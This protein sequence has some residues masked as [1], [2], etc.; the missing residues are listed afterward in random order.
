MGLRLRIK[1]KTKI[2]ILEHLQRFLLR[3]SLC[4]MIMKLFMITLF[5]IK[6]LPFVCFNKIFF[7]KTKTLYR[8]I[9]IYMYI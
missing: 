9:I 2:I 8:S 5:K 4:S 3:H 6:I 1:F 7:Y